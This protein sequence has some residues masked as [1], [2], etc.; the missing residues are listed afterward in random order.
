[1]N[2]SEQERT[3][4]RPPLDSAKKVERM[5]EKSRLLC[6]NMDTEMEIIAPLP[7]ERV[8]SKQTEDFNL[9]FYSATPKNIH[10][11]LFHSHTST[12]AY[13]GTVALA[14]ALAHRHHTHKHTAS[15]FPT[16]ILL[17]GV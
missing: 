4:D 8:Q 17:Q 16:T 1:M 15:H 2:K 7:C 5:R 9:N 11:S 13:T 3:R 6:M 14:L 12:Q 10:S